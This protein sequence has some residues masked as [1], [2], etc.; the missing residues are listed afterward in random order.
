MDKKPTAL[1]LFAGA[2]GFD[3]G[4]AAC[5]VHTLAAFN[6]NERSLAT[7]ALNF[8]RTRQVL[9]DITRDD[10][11]NYPHATI[12]QASPECRYQSKAIGAK[13]LGQ[14]QMELW[15]ELG[16]KWTDREE[17]D[18]ATRS[19]VTM[20][21]VVRWTE[22]KSAQGHPFKLIFVENVPEVERWG[23]YSA[24]MA[25]MRELGYQA[26]VLYFNSMFAPAFPAP[27]YES[28][29]RWYAVFSLDGLPLPD[30]DIRPPAYCKSCDRRVG[31]VQ[32]WKSLKRWGA[33]GEQYVYVCP[34]CGKELVP[35]Y[36]PAKD[37]LNWNLP[38]PLIGHRKKPL[39]EE[40]YHK[41]RQG[42][43]RYRHLSSFVMSYYGNAIYRTIDDP[44]GTVTT[45]DRHALITIPHAGA[46]VDE[47]GYR[48]L[49]FEES[50]RAMGY[51]ASF[52]FECGKTEALRE[53]GLS[54]TPAVAAMLVQR[55]L[56]ALAKTAEME[57]A[58]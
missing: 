7:H 23:G 38:T 11:R 25:D 51:P 5:N 2:G 13:L 28:R 9:T 1:T 49:T 30:L 37:L 6:H 58:A 53:I 27:C 32:S 52:R 17:D 57:V 16:G 4:F 31:A 40:T 8:P 48:M 47:C 10:P 22:A 15:P 43:V 14:N 39:V 50:R 34:G 54:V 46:T 45:K 41:I 19:R 3:A 55:G 36:H 44:I 42:L 35:F 18:P 33:Y 29:D 26:Q 12:L 21:E 56:A 24:W 20:N